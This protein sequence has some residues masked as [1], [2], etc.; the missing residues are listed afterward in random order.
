MS[1]SNVSNLSPR[2]RQIL[3]TA[4]PSSSRRD[5]PSG[6]A[7]SPR[8]RGSTSRPRA[9]ATC[10]PTSR[11][12]AT[13]CSRTRAP[14][15]SPTDR[16]FRLFID[17]LMQRARALDRRRRRASAR[18][19]TSIEPGAE[20]DARDGQAALR[21]D[22]DGG[23]RRRAARARALLAQAP[24][25]HP[26]RARRGPGRPRHVERQRAEPLPDRP[27]TEAD[28]QRIHNLLDDVVEGRTLG[29]LRELFERRLAS[30]R[31]QH[32]ELRRRAFQLGE[33][34]VTEEPSR[35]ETDRHRGAG[36]AA[37][38]ARV[39]GRG[40]REQVV[41]ALDEREK[42]RGAARRD[43]ARA[44]GTRSSSASEAGDLGGGQLCNRRARPTPSTAS[45]AGT[46]GVIGPTRMDYPRVVP[47]VTAT[48]HAM[49]EFIERSR[50][51]TCGGG[52][53]RRPSEGR[54]DTRDE[55]P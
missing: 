23:G 29:D 50:L 38:E 13:C 30:E 24:A 37:R 18:A 26:H 53:G 3:Y 21:A 10:W 1:R 7:R 34:A 5:S 54:S 20:R 19:S 4:S 11:R 40:G 31:V 39:L 2:A 25:L 22:G 42:P 12:R 32:D 16:A 44:K 6:R 47:L 41:T 9:S 46:V 51:G 8:R 52:R 36:E 17:A 55:S 35:G 27:A 15:A 33:A 48:A 49:S 43:D 14:A 28:L 45:A